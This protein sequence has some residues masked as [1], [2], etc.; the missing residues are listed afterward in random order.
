MDQMMINQT[1][2]ALQRGRDC[3]SVPFRVYR[4]AHVDVWPSIHSLHTPDRPVGIM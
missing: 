2:K 4:P 3:W 1:L